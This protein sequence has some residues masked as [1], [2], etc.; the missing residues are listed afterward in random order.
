VRPSRTTSSAMAEQDD[1]AS[2]VLRRAQVSKVRLSV[3]AAPR[4]GHA[5]YLPV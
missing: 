3:A 1:V 5:N 4:A 2:K